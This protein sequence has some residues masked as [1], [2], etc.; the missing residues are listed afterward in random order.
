MS[1]TLRICLKSHC[2]VRGYV[3]RKRVFQFKSSANPVMR[4]CVHAGKGV[5]SKHVYELFHKRKCIYFVLFR[6]IVAMTFTIIH[7]IKA[8]HTPSNIK[9]REE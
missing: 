9:P 2:G 5:E 4:G 3:G 8:K 6:V 7:K 1:M